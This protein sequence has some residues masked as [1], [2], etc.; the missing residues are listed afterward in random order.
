MQPHRR[1]FALLVS[2]AVLVLQPILGV[3][4]WMRRFGSATLPELVVSSAGLDAVR[5]GHHVIG[6]LIFGA[7]VFNL[8]FYMSMTEGVLQSISILWFYVI[9]YWLTLQA[10]LLPLLYMVTTSL[11]QPGHLLGEGA[12]RSESLGDRPPQCGHR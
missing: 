9:L 6:T 10:Y 5:S 2:A 8:S 3:E 7:L 1:R 12:D 11:Q 4:A